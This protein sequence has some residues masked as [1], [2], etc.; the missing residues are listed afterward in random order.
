M[1]AAVSATEALQQIR[2]KVK[3]YAGKKATVQT[4]QPVKLYKA[5]ARDGE[6]E[7][8]GFS[9]FV[10]MIVD[11]EIGGTFILRSYDP[12]ANYK[13]RF[14]QEVFTT[15]EL[16]RLSDV[17]F[18]YQTGQ[19]H[20]GFAFPDKKCCDRMSNSIRSAVANQANSVANTT[21]VK[22]M[23]EEN[24]K[25]KNVFRKMWKSITTA[26][27]GKG[28]KDSA[29][30]DKI[31][32]HSVNRTVVLDATGGIDVHSLPKVWKE[33]L[34]KKGIKKSELRDPQIAPHI[35]AEINRAST[36]LTPLA[37]GGSKPQPPKPAG[38]KK[39]PPP[40]APNR[41]RKPAIPA[42][43][44][45]SSNVDR[46]TLIKTFRKAKDSP[47]ASRAAIEKQIRDHGLDP[48]EVFEDDINEGVES[49]TANDPPSPAPAP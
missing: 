23:T 7:Y 27:G 9:G 10:V 47:N 20:F 48:A 37:G 24:K 30:D 39:K 5:K 35:M 34:K 16:Q 38:A 36:A 15:L 11:R 43:T 19:A 18:S 29:Q 42:K 49:K 14:E 40:P 31:E 1:A 28:K 45:P 6:W 13:M 46:Q 22:V 44:S 17:F 2:R 4:C 25:D 21:N 8:L 41:S 32:I 33:R 26:F 3:A 12:S